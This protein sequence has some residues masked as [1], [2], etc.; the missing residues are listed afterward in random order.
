[1]GRWSEPLVIPVQVQEFFYKKWWFF[2]LCALPFLGFLGL[3]L[4]RQRGERMRLELEVKNRTQTI[5]EQFKELN[6]TLIDD[7]AAVERYTKKK[8]ST[9]EPKKSTVQETY[10]LWLEKNTIKEIAAIR[11]FTEETILGHLTK[12]IVSRTISISDVLPEDKIQE[13][14]E[15]FYG[16][17]EESISPLKEKYGDKF[18]WEELRMFK[19]SLN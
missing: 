10:E 4:H 14:T 2:A 1:M 13:L 12:L 5:Q 19:A 8:K 15:A 18:T 17:K 9:K 11:K 7:E 6:I 3:W 16:Y